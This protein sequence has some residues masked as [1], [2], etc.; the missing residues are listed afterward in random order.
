[1][2]LGFKNVH[3]YKHYSLFMY[4]SCSL[5]LDMVVDMMLCVK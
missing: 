5:L 1:M 2:P 3:C 4:I